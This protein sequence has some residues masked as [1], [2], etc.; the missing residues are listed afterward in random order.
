MVPCAPARRSKYIT[1][2]QRKP[3]RRHCTTKRGTSVKTQ[4]SI[5]SSNLMPNSASRVDANKDTP[6]TGVFMR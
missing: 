1:V 3:R 6:S 5:A 2:A 4:T